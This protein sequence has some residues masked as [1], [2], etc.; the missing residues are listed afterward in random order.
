LVAAIREKLPG[1]RF[2]GIGGEAMAAQGVD[3]LIPARDLA[4]VGFVEVARH[5]PRIFRALRVLHR[6]LKEALPALCILVDFPD[7][8]FLAMRLAKRRGVPVMY[9]ISPQVWAWRRY[10]VR[11]IAR[12]VDRMV[13]IFPFEEGFYRQYGVPVDFVGHPFRETL[14]DLPLRGDL[15]RSW[16]LDPRAFTVAL[17]PGS[18][19]GEITRHLPTLLETGAL[20]HH[21]IPETQFLL[22]LASTAPR[23]LV[24]SMVREFWGEGAREHSPL[25]PHPSP[26]PQPFKAGWGKTL[27]EGRKTHRSPR[28]PL[29]ITTQGAYPALTAAHLAIA[30]SGTV[31]V[32]AALA[33]TPTIIVYRLS[34]LTFLLGKVLIKVPFIG[35]AN[36]LA[37]EGLFPELIQDDFQPRRIVAEVVKLFREPSRLA[38]LRRGLARVVTALGEPGASGRAAAVALG[39]M[40]RQGKAGG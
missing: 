2:L 24:E 26:L 25:L 27:R 3:I 21:L 9:Y 14:P 8:N 6:V 23:D 17:I 39:L 38:A 19:E 20:L 35:M 15:L 4:V 34:R 31:T 32:E 28:P 30:A 10:R 13:V 18:R 16:G 5:L 11:T 7:F 1:V 40:S 36:L 22:P 33:G 12:L 37:G 29:K